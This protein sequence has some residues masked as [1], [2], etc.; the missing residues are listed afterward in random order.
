MTTEVSMR[1]AD[2]INF[3]IVYFFSSF[4]QST[5]IDQIFYCAYF[6]EGGTP[7]VYGSF[8]ARGPIGAVADSLH[9]SSQQHRILNPLSEAKD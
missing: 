5:N 7:T 3:H 2:P 4:I 6:G 1:R 8:Q 9:H